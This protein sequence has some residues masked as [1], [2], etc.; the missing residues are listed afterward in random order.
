MRV[1]FIMASPEY[2]RYYDST[3]DELAARGHDVAVA[4]NS[5]REKKPI[6]LQ[7]LSALGEHVRV[8]GVTPSPSGQ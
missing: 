3:I 6:G 7:R 2:L 4:V 8:L 1:L 5:R